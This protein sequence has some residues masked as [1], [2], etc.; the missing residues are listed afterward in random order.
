MMVMVRGNKIMESIL[1]T[2]DG[3]HKCFLAR[4]HLLKQNIGFRE[5][6]LL[7]EPYAAKDIK[8]KVGQVIT[9]VFAS[10]AGVWRELEILEL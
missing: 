3:C 4:E 5:I 6:N 10:R 8:E 9:P 2:I 7:H 1:Y